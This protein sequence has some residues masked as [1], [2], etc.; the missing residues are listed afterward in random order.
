MSILIMVIIAPTSALAHTGLKSSTPANKQVVKEEVQEI[1]MS[2]NTDIE[3][4]SS[5]KVTDDQGTE[6]PVSDTIIDKSKMSGKLE[7]PLR[8]G[9]YAVDWKIIGRDGHPIK[10]TFSFSVEIPVV[11][12]PSSSP[13]ESSSPIATDSP[14]PTPQETISP[15]PSPSDS[16]QPETAS[17]SSENTSLEATSNASQ[18]FVIVTAAALVVFV[19]AYLRRK[20]RS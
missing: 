19:V 6:Y 3:K 5:F 7:Q 10:G 11:E 12:T 15:S 2:F 13:I 17:D 18:I 14:S 9:K 20:K 4:L 8:D 1:A 16:A